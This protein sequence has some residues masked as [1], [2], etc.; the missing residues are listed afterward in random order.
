VDPHN[1]DGAPWPPRANAA[2]LTTQA[3]SE[4]ICAPCL[5]GQ[6]EGEYIV[7]RWRLDIKTLK[8][9]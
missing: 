2:I 6:A 7:D 9:N 8:L 3:H 5:L 4:V 1:L